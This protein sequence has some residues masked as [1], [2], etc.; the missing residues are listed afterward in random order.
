MI[1]Q[2]FNLLFNT[3]DIT[4]IMALVFALL[5]FIITIFP[6]LTKFEQIN[7]FLSFLKLSENLLPSDG[8]SGKIN[9]LKFT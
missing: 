2:A 8:F 3:K 1:T 7:Q 6:I 4:Q 5:I 9:W